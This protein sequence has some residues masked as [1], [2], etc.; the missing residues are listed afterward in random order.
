MVLATWTTI[1]VFVDAY[2]HSTDPGLETFW[3][4]WHALFYSGFLATAAWL[5]HVAWKRLDGSRS[6]FDAAPRAHRAALYGIVV[7]AIGGMGDAVWHTVFGVETSLDALL[8]PTHLM[9][10][11]GLLTISSTPLRAAWT[12][13][14]HDDATTMRKFGPVLTSA[15]LTLSGIAFFFEYLWMPVDAFRPRIRYVAGVMGEFDAAFGVAGIIISTAVMMGAVLLLTRRWTAPF[16]TVT[17]LLTVTNVLMAIGFDN[18][19]EALP[20]VLIAGLVGDLLV[21]VDA[22]RQLLA[23]GIPLV[24]WSSYFVQVG[25]LDAGLGWP[26]EIWGGAIFFAVLVGLVLEAGFEQAARLERDREAIP[27]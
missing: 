11:L 26:P 6:L 2:Q 14:N 27:A 1:G 9:L 16:G 8:S 12:D 15:V 19:L 5:V 21:R 4:P 24:L 7:F 10:W 17:V 23:A 3:T 18:D 20:A 25:R 13:R 22:S